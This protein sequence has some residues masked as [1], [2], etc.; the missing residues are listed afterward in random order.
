MGAGLGKPF[1]QCGVKPALQPP[2]YVFAVA[3]AV[4]YA[5][6]GLAC[7]IL[8]RKSGRRWTPG[9]KAAVVTLVLL[10]LWPILFFNR[11]MP[12]AAFVAI[13]GLLGMVVGTIAVIWREGCSASAALLSPLAAWLLFASYLSAR[14]IP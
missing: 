10:A 8:W 9:V 13:V 4:L 2:G 1:K 5:L 7:V 6:Y 3:W 12:V 14:S 11:C